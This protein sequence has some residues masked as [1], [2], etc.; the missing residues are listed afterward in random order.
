[1]A[2]DVGG[3]GVRKGRKQPALLGPV[4]VHALAGCIPDQRAERP[5]LHSRHWRTKPRDSNSRWMTVSEAGQAGEDMSAGTYEESLPCGGTLKVRSTEWE[6]LY[7][8]PGPDLRHNGTFVSVPGGSIDKYILAFNENWSEYEKLKSSMPSGGEFSKTG[9]MG[10]TIR[11]GRFAQGVCI[12]SYHMP[13]S[14]KQ[15]LD[16]II[17]GYRYASQR[18]PEIQKLL[19]SL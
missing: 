12:Q 13:I 15:Q 11:I 6:I 14:S 3:G 16:T 4:L 8:F 19:A 17:S 5:L 1:M 2:E 7:Y 18:A 10:M 9:K